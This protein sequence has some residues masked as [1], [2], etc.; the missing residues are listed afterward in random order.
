MIGKIVDFLQIAEKLECEYRLTRMSDG[1]NQAVASHSWNMA[2]MAMVLRPYLQ[3]PVDMLRV[4]QM[5][6]LHDLPEA[7]AHDVPLHQ[8]TPQVRA[9]K[10][11]RESLAIE[12][13]VGMLDNDEVRSCMTEYEARQTP[14]AQLVKAL[15]VLDTGVQHMCASDLS[16]VGEFYNNF[17]WKMFFDD[18]FVRMFDFEPVL[19]QVMDEIRARVADRLRQEQDIDVK[20]FKK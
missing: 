14:E 3:T 1:K 16:Y 20:V 17:Y 7:I 15:D 8:Q 5:C 4:L 2:M 19:R 9:E 12:Q 11:V 18:D 10:H 6:L 13:I